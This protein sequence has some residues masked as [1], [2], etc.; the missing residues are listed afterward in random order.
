MVKKKALIM[1][2]LQ[3]DFCAGGSLAV[4]GGDEVIALA[5][6]LQAC[7]TEVIATQDWHPANHTSFAA[8]HPGHEVGDIISI[9]GMPQ[10]LW[11]EHCIQGQKGSAFHDELS[12]TAA[13]KVFQKGIDKD[14]DSYSAFFDNAQKRSTGLADHLQHLGIDEVYILGLA[15]DYCVKFSALDA[16]ELGFDVYVIQDACRGVNLKAN[17]VDSAISE[18]KAAGIAV[19]QSA[20]IIAPDSPHRG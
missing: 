10:I 2:D 11:P 1:V 19:I 4:P 18:M 15:T 12:L 13:T 9:Q 3:N 7:F 6:R 14:I 20:D 17:D 8:N 16:A 5:N